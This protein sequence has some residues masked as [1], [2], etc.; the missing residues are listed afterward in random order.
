[1]DNLEAPTKTKLTIMSYNVQ[2]LPIPL[3]H[4]LNLSKRQDAIIDYICSLDDLH[5]IDILVLNEVFTKNCYDMLTKGKMKDKFP[6]H[7]AVIGT[8]CQESGRGSTS[9]VEVEEDGISGTS[10]N[11]RTANKKA[12]GARAPGPSDLNSEAVS[13]KSPPPKEEPLEVPTLR[14][15][16]SREATRREQETSSFNTSDTNSSDQEEAEET[17]NLDSCDTENEGDSDYILSLNC[18]LERENKIEGKASSQNYKAVED[19]NG[20]PNQRRNGRRYGGDDATKRESTSCDEKARC[21]ETDDGM[22]IPEKRQNLRVNRR[23][24]GGADKLIQKS[25]SLPSNPLDTQGTH[26]AGNSELVT[27]ICTSAKEASKKDGLGKVPHAKVD[28]RINEGRSRRNTAYFENSNRDGK[29]S[30]DDSNDAQGAFTN[31]FCDIVRKAIMSPS[32]SVSRAENLKGKKW[33]DQKKNKE[34]NNQQNVPS[35]DSVSG[36][37]KFYQ[38]LNGGVMVLSKHPFMHKHALIYSNFVFPEIFCTKGAIYV[39]VCLNKKPVNV[40][41]THLQAG[42]GSYWQNCRW[43]QLNELS[44]W[45]Y[46]G[47]PSLHIKKRE[48]LFFVGDFN[49]RYH[50][51][52]LFFDRVLS[53]SCLNSSVTKK[54]LQTTFDSYLNDYCMHMERDYSFKNKDTLDYILVN[55]DTDVETLVP[56]TAIQ[57]KYRPI[58]IIKSW[59]GLIPYRCLYTYH[60]SDHFPIYGTFY[61]PN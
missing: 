48:P 54:S 45:V 35:F 1:M 6:Y 41:A 11:E 51:D 22:A 36:K 18:G 24:A 46:N 50:L 58:H 40:I 37:S 17:L 61:I 27:G 7:T 25:G 39:K 47:T 14:V 32:S 30:T 2:M 4:R 13:T 21:S 56:Q 12:A 9:I 31:E 42:Y 44:N 28:E 33:K 57:K 8:K 49:I 53:S 43:R 19:S 60:P 15:T 26:K 34:Q 52:K 38:F 29:V 23:G 10:T 55:N 5:N 3:D 16:T 59:L 20:V